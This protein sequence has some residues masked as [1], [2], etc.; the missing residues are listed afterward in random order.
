MTDMIRIIKGV[1]LG[2]IL[3]VST[4]TVFFT[5][6]T[7]YWNDIAFIVWCLTIVITIDMFDKERSNN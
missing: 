3:V 7:P 1:L 4:I 6:G 5:D 2:A